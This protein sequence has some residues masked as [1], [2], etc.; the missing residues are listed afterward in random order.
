M[1]DSQW[2]DEDFDRL[3]DQAAFTNESNE[4]N[5][6]LSKAEDILLSSGEIIPISHPVTCAIIDLN[7]VGGWVSNAMDIHPFKSLYF[8]KVEGTFKNV[9]MR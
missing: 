9:V 5:S 4:R 2:K 6:L 3:L 8:R 1:N 7:V